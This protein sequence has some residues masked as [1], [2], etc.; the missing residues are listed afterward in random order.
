MLKS[1]RKASLVLLL[2]TL[3]SY[4]SVTKA[5]LI[6]ADGFEYM[7]EGGATFTSLTLPSANLGFGTIDVVI[8]GIVVDTITSDDGVAGGIDTFSFDSGVTTFSLIGLDMLLDTQ[9]PGFVTAFPVFIDFSGTA[10]RLLQT[11]ILVDLNDP[12][13]VSEPGTVAIL[14]LGSMLLL[15]RRRKILA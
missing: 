14:L 4:A 11:A 15:N 2:C 3:C 10:T 13:A 7:L 9:D 8:N 1:I 12:S 6:F 5:S